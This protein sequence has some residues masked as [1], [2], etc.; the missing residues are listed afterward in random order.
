MGFSR[1]TGILK[2]RAAVFAPRM[3]GAPTPPPGPAAPP[4]NDVLPVIT[5]TFRDGETL[6]CSTG[7]WQY[8]PTSYAYQWYEDGSPIIGANTATF[9][10]TP[11]FI[12]V[13]LHCEVTATNAAG[14]S[15]PAAANAVSSP[16]KPIYDLDPTAAVFVHTQGTGVSVGAAVPTWTSADG[17]YSLTQSLP[18]SR[19]TRFAD[20]VDFDGIDD[21]MTGDALASRFGSAFSVI[22]S[23]RFLA[24]DNVTRQLWGAYKLGTSTGIRTCAH[25]NLSIG[26]AAVLTRL[27]F[28]LGG[29]SITEQI[30]M[31]GLYPL[32]AAAT[33]TTACTS[34]NPNTGG[35]AEAYRAVS[36]TPTLLDNGAWPAVTLAPDRFAVGAERIASAGSYWQGTMGCFVIM[37]MELSDAQVETV[38]AALDAEGAL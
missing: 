33:F 18:S 21:Y 22:S 13:E 27:R 23:T 5:G 31:T 10:I 29:T 3:I 16:L 32:G 2:G 20:G 9:S 14:S 1:R 36:P 8:S 24:E 12:P 34:P 38:R 7:T 6:T 15:T 17:S 4:I 19:P 28:T 35:T 30:D 37:S 26:T 11:S 25:Q